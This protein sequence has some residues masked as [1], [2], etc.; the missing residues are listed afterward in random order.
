MQIM[1][2]KY[3]ILIHFFIFLK[4]DKNLKGDKKL[5]KVTKFKKVAQIKR[6]YTD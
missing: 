5:K 6:N 1:L 4:S 2:E 3:N